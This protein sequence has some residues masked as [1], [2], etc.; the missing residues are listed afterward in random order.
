[1]LAAALALVATNGVESVEA[2]RPGEYEVKA[3]FLYNFAKFV[4]W[5]D[6][7]SQGPTFVIGVLGEDPFGGVLDKTFHGKTILDKAVEV[8]RLASP[9]AAREAQI[10]FVS[11]SE[12][13][14]LAAI[15]KTLSGATVLTVGEMDRFTDRGGMIAF[16][17]RD[18]AVRF[19]INLDEV[20]RANLKMSSQL[21]RLAQRVID[22]NGG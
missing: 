7:A 2:P 4:K 10:V 15:L 5:P 16:Q 18:E 13:E 20:E 22:T 3:A 6:G 9:E 14:H 19:E 12:K 1:M 11:S 8:R 17:L 21:I